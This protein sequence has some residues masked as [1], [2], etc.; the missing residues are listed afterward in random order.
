MENEVK[1][2]CICGREFTGWGNNPYPISENL[3]D[4]C[5]DECNS[6]YVIPAKIVQLY[7]RKEEE[8]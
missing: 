2:C 5:C 6:M 8:K 1:K 4:T 7:S 3:D